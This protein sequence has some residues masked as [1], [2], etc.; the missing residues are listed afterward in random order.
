MKDILGD[1]WMD[2]DEDDLLTDFE[3]SDLLKSSL[4]EVGYETRYL[5]HNLGSMFLI[6]LFAIFIMTLVV[7]MSCLRSN[8]RCLGWHEKLKKKFLWNFYIRLVSEATFE[9]CFA[10]YLNLFY[11]GVV[12]IQEGS[13]SFNPDSTWP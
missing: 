1:N 7:I 6:F 2:V 11:S 5:S 13:L 4:N 9:L 3:D 8:K 12:E 10:G